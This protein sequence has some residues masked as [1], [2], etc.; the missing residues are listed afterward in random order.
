MEY[1]TI[2][3]VLEFKDGF[4]EQ[5]VE[6]L[7]S[8]SFLKLIHDHGTHTF[9]G[10]KDRYHK[11]ELVFKPTELNPKTN[12]HMSYLLHVS[13]HSDEGLC[14]PM[15]LYREKS[16]IEPLIKIL[17]GFVINNK[18]KEIGLIVKDEFGLT[19]KDFK[20]TAGDDFSIKENYNDDFIEVDKKIVKHL[21][22][23]NKKGLILL[24]GEPGT[25]KTTYIKHL[26]DKLEK[27]I[28]FVPPMMTGAIAD[29]AFIPFLMKYPD[30]IL[31]IE[32]AETVIKDRNVTG[33]GNSVSNIL[34][35]TDG[36]L[37]ECLKIQ[38]IATFNTERTQI[39]KALLRKG[40]LITDYKF[41]KLSVEKSNTLL[42]KTGVKVNVDKP[43]SLADIYYYNETN[44]NK[45]DKPT[46]G[47]I[48]NK[49]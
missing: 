28:I 49:K 15:L 32:D 46:I 11:S 27:Q 26:A 24:H 37:G 17:E 4:S 5:L 6:K 13:H 23:K 21:S 44:T 19:L 25:G 48:T 38:I 14:R 7:K 39:D 47:F 8:V 16:E 42:K 34:N 18:L 9:N 12:N 1:N 33:N 40:R 2:P 45:K 29:P 20:L 41:E 31:I 43:M 36:I 22:T 3:K 30:S 10:K 35:L